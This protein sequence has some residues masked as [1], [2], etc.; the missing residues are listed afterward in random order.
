MEMDNKEYDQTG[1]KMEEQV[2]LRVLFRVL[3]Q[4]K[5][6]VILI[7]LLFAIGSVLY[8]LSVKNEYRA[9]AVLVPVSNGGD[10]GGLSRLA[11]QF[12]GL[13]SLAGMSIGGS[14]GVSKSVTAIEVMRT[15]GFAERFIAT[16]GLEVEAFAATDWKKSTRK[17][18]I[19]P[20]LYDL[21]KEEWVR[22]KLDANLPDEPTSWELYVAL[23]NRIFVSQDSKTGIVRI[24]AE[25]YS[26]DVAKRWVDLLVKEINSYMKLRDR[27]DAQNSIAYL[28][29]QIN[30]TSIAEMRSIFYELIEEQT[31]KLMLAEVS[32]E[33]VFKTISEAKVPEQRIRPK[34][35]LIVIMG[36]F[37][38]LILACTF[39][40][41]R[42]Y[43]PAV[44]R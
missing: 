6:I 34:R 3:F 7:T 27:E 39:V 14:S 28:K 2:D 10:G 12:G 38:G 18:V 31:K 44:R 19:D 33:Y 35:A 21:E 24:E 37:L 22:S 29:Q 42:H 13:A 36:T 4:K 9:S 8:A 30:K 1:P 16:H 20:E 5:L 17:L 25:H 15:W 43:P 11:G 26:P 32:E 23:S 41:I 40:L